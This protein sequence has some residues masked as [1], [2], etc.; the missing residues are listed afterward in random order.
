M[1]KSTVKQIEKEL[2]YDRLRVSK[3]YLKFRIPT[4]Y[5]FAVIFPM[6]LYF[7]WKVVF[8]LTVSTALSVYKQNFI[9]Q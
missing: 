8:I 1:V 7:Y 2:I 3:V 5:S 9:A 4:I 6:N